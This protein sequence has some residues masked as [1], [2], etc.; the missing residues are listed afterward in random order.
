MTVDRQPASIERAAAMEEL[1][2]AIER[3]RHVATTAMPMRP[4]ERAKK[5]YADRRKRATLFPDS[6]VL[7]HEPAWDI[8]LDLFVAREEDALVSVSSACIGA[9]VA[10]TTALRWIATL[11]RK[12]FLTLHDDPDDMRRRYVRL[13]DAGYGLMQ[14]YLQAL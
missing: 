3:V 5:L 11:E 14:T 10:P 2:R 4:V 8:L 1:A 7:F 12:G 9:S 6:D 13:S